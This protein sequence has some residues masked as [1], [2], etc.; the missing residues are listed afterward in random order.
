MLPAF[1]DALAEII[2]VLLAH[3]LEVYPHDGQWFWRWRAYHVESTTGV[4]T[5]A[6][7]FATALTFRLQI[8]MAP[9]AQ[10]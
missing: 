3:G 10:N 9:S 8:P 7:A 1:S 6:E 4:A 5:M 2:D